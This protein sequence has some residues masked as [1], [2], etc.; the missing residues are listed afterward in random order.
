MLERELEP[1]ADAED[2]A[3]VGHARAQNLVE[4]LTLQLVHRRACRADAREHGE[5]G[6]RHVVDELGAEPSQRD[7]DRADVPRAV[8]ADAD[9][10]SF[11]FVDGI[12]LD[13]TRSAVFSAR[14]TALYAA[15]AV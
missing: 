4:S 9:L 12:P 14:P 7:L 10:H 6:T 5:V 11:P 8:V 3:A 13:S 15:S 2:R 1:E